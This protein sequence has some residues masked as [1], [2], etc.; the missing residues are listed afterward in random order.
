MPHARKDQA[1]SL[2][3]LRQGGLSRGLI[4]MTL[5]FSAVRFEQPSSDV[6]RN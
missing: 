3:G 1:T 5:A 2:P 6:P 4:P